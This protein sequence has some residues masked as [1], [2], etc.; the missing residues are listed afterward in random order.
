VKRHN[1]LDFD[2][3]WAKPERSKKSYVMLT[4]GR[5]HACLPN[6]SNASLPRSS[7]PDTAGY[8]RLMGEDEEGTH[9]AVIELRREVIAPRID[10]HHGRIVKSTGD[11]FL[12]EFASVVDAVRCAVEIQRGMASRN[13][14]APVA[15]ASSFASALISATSSSR[16][17][18]FT[19]T[20]STLR[21]DSRL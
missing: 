14:G 16:P 9:A 10:E 1:R 5:G 2:I 6:R 12:A 3:L 21:H 11:G 17:V 4:T 15:A 20:A 13:E 19:A 8:G 18:T 7:P